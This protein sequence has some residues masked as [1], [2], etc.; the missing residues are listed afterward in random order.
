MNVMKHYDEKANAYS[1][2]LNT[3]SSSTHSPSGKSSNNL[4][5]QQFRD[6]K[7]DP[8]GVDKP[9]G[10]RKREAADI[11]RP[12]NNSNLFKQAKINQ[13]YDFGTAHQMKNHS[14]AEIFRTQGQASPNEFN[15]YYL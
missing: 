12:N 9:L 7:K 5:K 4:L 1:K 15:Q 8:Y 3:H 10:G 2:K 6:L 11:I 13:S 14:Q